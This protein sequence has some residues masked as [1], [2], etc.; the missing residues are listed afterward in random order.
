MVNS[1]QGDVDNSKLESFRPQPLHEPPTK[2]LPDTTVHPPTPPLPSY[3]NLDARDLRFNS[4]LRPRVTYPDR[5]IKRSIERRGLTGR[6]V[7][8][9]TR[10]NYIVQLRYGVHTGATRRS[11]RCS[12]LIAMRK[13]RTKGR[14]C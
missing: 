5:D 9:F 13:P 7:V 6:A 8:A 10:L 1:A 4:S 11:D 2:L 14:R 12:L 3:V